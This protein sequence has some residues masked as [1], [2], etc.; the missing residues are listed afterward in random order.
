MKYLYMDNFRGFSDTLIS[1]KDVNFF[2]GENSTGKSSVISLLKLLTT[3][4]FWL[5]S[6][7]KFDNADIQL[8]KGRYDD[9]VSV[10]AASKDSFSVGSYG[11]A[12]PV[13]RSASNKGKGKDK[14]ENE[15]QI[16]AFL[17]TFVSRDGLPS[18]SSYIYSYKGEEVIVRVSENQLKY[19]S[20]KNVQLLTCNNIQECFKRWGDIAKNDNRGYKIVPKDVSRTLIELPILFYPSII[21]GIRGNENM[22]PFALSPAIFKES[23][24]WLAPIRSKPKLTYDE[25][26]LDYSPEG[27][28]TPY[29]IKKLLGK[30]SE[31]V[32]FKKFLDTLGKDSGLFET[33]EI[34]HYGNSSTSP[35]ELDVVLNKRK[36]SINN[37][38]Y[39]VSQALPIIVELFVRANDSAYAVQQ[40]EVHL[41]PKAQA[42]LGDAFFQLA[43]VENKK[44]L[45]ETHSDY[46]LDRFRSNYRNESNSESPSS[47][48]LF[49]E[50]DENGNRVTPV[51]I[52]QQGDLSERQP[53]AYREFFIREE[54]LNLGLSS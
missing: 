32:A 3:T 38:G 46:T 16:D 27:E 23:L 37:V 20:R 28:H 48:V 51:E 52:D 17:L 7:A 36:L 41:H 29:V 39:G 30:K 4:E 42:A 5:E 47:Q 11:K 6:P 14:E 15:E 1:F 43:T 45:I 50:R 18:L 24:I 44:F 34:L 8:G 10:H 25:Y 21:E 31:A 2:V 26:K 53:D 49:F 13:N 22:N 9:L 35:F 12:L 33:I 19:K 40:P 54:M